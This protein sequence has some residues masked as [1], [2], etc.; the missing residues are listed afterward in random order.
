MSKKVKVFLRGG[1]S[2]CGGKKRRI[3]SFC[4]VRPCPAVSA[5][6]ET[7]QELPLDVEV[8]ALVLQ[9][10]DVACQPG[11]DPFVGVSEVV[12]VVVVLVRFPNPL[13][14][15][16]GLGLQYPYRQVIFLSALPAWKNVNQIWTLD[17]GVLIGFVIISGWLMPNHKVFHSLVTSP[18][19]YAKF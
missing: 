18:V 8:K 4:L 1:A 7:S 11:S 2:P 13:A 3:L 15:G 16:S 19:R 5:W 14:L 6:C 10:P 9:A 17:N 12:S